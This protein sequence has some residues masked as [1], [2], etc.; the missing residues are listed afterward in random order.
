MR[1]VGTAESSIQSPRNS[2]YVSSDALDKVNVANS[3]PCDRPG[4]F[5]TTTEFEF[6]TSVKLH[7]S[8]TNYKIAYYNCLRLH[9]IFK[10]LDNIQETQTV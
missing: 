2:N 3:M 8:Q 4:N 5:N 7:R 9:I 1:W 10:T 6:W